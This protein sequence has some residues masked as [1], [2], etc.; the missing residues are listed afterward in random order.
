MPGDLQPGQTT[1][2][3]WSV[4]DQEWVNV[5]RKTYSMNANGLW[6]GSII[7]DWDLDNNVW[8]NS[9]KSTTFSDLPN[10]SSALLGELWDNSW[11]KNLRSTYSFSNEVNSALLEQWDETSMAFNNS[12][13]FQSE[14]NANKIPIRKIGMQKWD[15]TS[16]SWEN[17]DY[18]RRITYFWTEDEATST[19]ELI[20]SNKCVIPN[21]YQTG[22]NIACDIPFS[23]EQLYLEVSSLY[24]QVLVR[25][26]VANHTVQIDH[27]LAAGMYIV[28]IGTSDQVYHLEKIVFGQ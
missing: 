2:Q 7:E 25:Q 26:K 21:P 18:T 4:P 1:A 12:L 15:L 14:F 17:R 8:I 3:R 9:I 5:T 19:N 28:K 27:S 11:V 13:R 16:E 24:G 23:D 6:S 10:N 20:T 22:A